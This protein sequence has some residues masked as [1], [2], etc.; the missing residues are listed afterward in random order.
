M[1]AAGVAAVGLFGGLAPL[2]QALAAA[3]SEGKQ[4]NIL[5]LTTEDICPDLGCYGDPAAVTP[6]I[7]KLAGEGMRFTNCFDT[8][9]VCAPSRAC[10]ISGM[11]SPSIGCQ[12]MRTATH[13][14]LYPELVKPYEAVPPADVKGFP[15]FLRAAGYY[16]TN[17][18][19]TDYQM[20]NP[21][22]IWDE[23][24][25]TAHWRNRPDKSQ[26]FFAVFNHEITHEGQ[27]R[28][29]AGK[30]AQ[31][32]DPAKV[33]L[34]PYYPD[35]P[36]VRNDWAVYYDNINTMD[37]QV[38]QKLKQLNEDGLADNTIVFFF[39]DNGRGLP[40]AKR[41]IYDSGMHVPLII[42]WP[43]RIKP[44]T[45][46][47]DLVSFVDFAPTVLSLAGVK[48]PAH[49]QGQAFLGAQQQPARRYVYA[50]RDRMDNVPDF[51]RCV[52][53]K[54]FKYI[55]NFKPDLPYAAT[56]AYM[57]QM[58]S[59][60]A[61]RRLNAEGKLTG[62]QKQFFTHP[63]PVEELY[64]IT[65]DPHEVNNLAADP[66]YKD[67][68]A[69]LRHELDT[70]MAAIKDLGPIDEHEMVAKMWPG[71]VQP[72]TAAPAIEV[73][74]QGD[75]AT[76]KITCPTE[77]ASIAWTTDALPAGGLGLGQG[78]KGKK[79]GRNGKKGK[80]ARKQTVGGVRGM[81]AGAVG[82]TGARNAAGAAAE[83]PNAIGTS[84]AP[85]GKQPHWLLYTGPVAVPAGATVHARAIRYGYKVS[86]V[87]TR[88]A[89]A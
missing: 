1:K 11:Y 27:I 80:N 84:A 75:K 31:K 18:F 10:L 4:P 37:G 52:R 47:E 34:P 51:V 76:V 19:K 44:G 15:E 79:N 53:D 57:D 40:R 64:D 61:M 72:V 54:K 2:Q 5:W 35:T 42:R 83:D 55:R 59:M 68:L 43:G 58:P 86:A 7:D 78:G 74:T 69:R 16:C 66:K 36:E 71:G 65:K 41:W 13:T 22:T 26:P 49:M 20:G 85:V 32:T 73:S 62:A 60:Q 28:M 45:V 89:G 87:A 9:G 21:L 70:W 77:G 23:C 17:N 25:K 30:K 46:N 29:P 3:M 38:A 81:A 8:A 67:E 24:S 50:A 56:S 12:H 82:T 88:K 39:G 48:A 14:D 63:R 33:V 6:T